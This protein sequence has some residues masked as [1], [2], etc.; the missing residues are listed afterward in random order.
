MGTEKV[1][2][3]IP[4]TA[5]ALEKDYNQIK[6][7]SHQVYTYLKNIPLDTIEKLYKNSEL[8]SELLSGILLAL[9]NHGVET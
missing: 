4:V 3:S 2:N 8:Q 7:D 5:S 1:L 9:G 6:K